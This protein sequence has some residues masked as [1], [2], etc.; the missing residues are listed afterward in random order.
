LLSFDR[1]QKKEPVWLEDKSYKK[2][3]LSITS[4]SY[5]RVINPNT[6]PYYRA[7]AV[8]WILIKPVPGFVVVSF[9]IITI[10][11][12]VPDSAV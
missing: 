9:A 7:A 8:G 6:K 11:E 4:V 3:C 1:L 5:K 12:S 2:N 10:I